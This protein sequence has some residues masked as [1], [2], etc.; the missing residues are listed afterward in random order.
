MGFSDE[1]GVPG[2]FARNN[3]KDRGAVGDGATSDVDKRSYDSRRAARWPFGLQDK[4]GRVSAHRLGERGS[5]TSAV[6]E[7]SES[8]EENVR[9]LKSL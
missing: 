4:I 1:F 9:D 3:W 8:A 7:A 5:G 2:H 6:Q